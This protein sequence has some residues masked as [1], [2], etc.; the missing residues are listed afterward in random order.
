[1]E[2]KNILDKISSLYITKNIFDYIKDENFKLKL[3][4]YSKYFQ[5]KL[6]IN[7]TLC[8]EKYINKFGF[9]LNNYL[10]IDEEEFDKNTNLYYE[11]RKKEN[12]ETEL[13][14]EKFL[15]NKKYDDFLSKNN[16]NK[17]KFTKIIYETIKNKEIK[18]INEED[19]TKKNNIILISIYSPFF[20]IL[21]K[22]KFFENR[23]AIYISTYKMYSLYDGDEDYYNKFFDRLNKSNVNYS[24]VYFFFKRNEY[25]NILNEINIDFNK[26]KKL[27]IKEDEKYHRYHNNDNNKLFQ[28]LFSFKNIENNLI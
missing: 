3:F 24:S 7:Y 9:D 19:F 21:S 18:D 20:D 10:Y 25:I 28:I 11:Y 6:N 4:L 2:N 23:C 15:L 12:K 5:K 22:T 14:C 26:I 16:L 27:I 17:D 1:M 13:K 8:Y